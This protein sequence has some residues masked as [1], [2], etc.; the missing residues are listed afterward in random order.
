M[1][2]PNYT[3]IQLYHSTTAAAVPTAAN[4]A[5]GELA[6]NITDGK[7]YYEDGSG[8]VQ[9]IASKGAGTIGGSTTQIQYNNA[10]ALAGSSDMTYT[11]ATNTVLLTTLNLTNALG[12]I[13][14]GTGQSTYTTGD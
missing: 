12:A 14:G 10:G 4:L 8:V 1:A 13:Y 5:Q 6:I 3:P 9:V 2:Q 7:L 11:S